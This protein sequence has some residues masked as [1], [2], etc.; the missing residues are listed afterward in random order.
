MAS[1]EN[2]LF[3]ESPASFPANPGIPLYEPASGNDSYQAANEP[4]LAIS[5]SDSSELSSA[6]A[7]AAPEN[8]T[9]VEVPTDKMIAL[10]LE[11]DAEEEEAAAAKELNL[12]H[13]LRLSRLD[14]PV[15]LYLKQVRD[16]P[17][18][19]PAREGEIFKRIDDASQRIE[20]IIHRFGFAAKEYI[21]MAEKLVAHPPRERWDRVIEEKFIENR[22]S[23]LRTLER[24][25]AEVRAL[26]GQAEQ[27]YAEWRRATSPR[28][29]TLLWKQYLAIEGKLLKKFSKFG[30][31]PKVREEMALFAENLYDKFTYQQAGMNPGK[32]LEV[33]AARS[34]LKV[35]H[36]ETL[37]RMDCTEFMQSCAELRIL[38]ARIE[39]ART[40]MVEANLR[41]VISIAKRYVNR[42]INFL[43]LIQDGNLGLMAAVERFEYRRGCRFSTY[44]TW[45]IRQAISRSIAN[46]ARTIRIPVNM[47]EILGRLMR[48]EK[49]LAQELGREASA[50][51][52]AEEMEL[53]AGKIRALQRMV[54]H[55]I[56]LQTPVGS[57]EEASVGDFI[58]DESALN[59]AETLSMDLLKTRLS[60]VL[61]GLDSREQEVLRLRFGLED[62]N[63][64]TLEEI[65]KKIQN[66]PRTNP[67]D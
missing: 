28:K 7:S 27:I 9:H 61:A 53:P 17:M 3:N 24:L 19:T 47:F 1:F 16:L 2:A 59:P 46:Q 49:K 12:E 38:F 42:G 66:H 11:G 57:E 58:E 67:S 64:E 29:K 62:G 35:E 37:A 44:G 45:W 13:Q 22:E 41:L 56:S 8:G 50:E 31:K 5:E 55:P 33:R 48:A 20:Q 34:G 32:L 15:Q 10:N 36:L 6:F 21:A 51:E 63:V 43:D 23:H 30:C 52:V 54:Q 14:D 18:L 60:S 25:I 40:E 39:T 65:G 4:L 26:D